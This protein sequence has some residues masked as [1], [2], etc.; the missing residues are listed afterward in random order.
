MQPFNDEVDKILE[1]YGL[2]EPG[3]AMVASDLADLMDKKEDELKRLQ[4]E[5]MCLR[6]DVDRL[7]TFIEGLQDKLKIVQSDLSG[8]NFLLDKALIDNAILVQEITY[9]KEG[10]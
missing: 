10:K 2:D 6:E 3:Y 8:K 5:N 7:V 9:L 4:N 1:Q